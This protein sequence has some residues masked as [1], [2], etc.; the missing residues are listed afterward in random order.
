MGLI[1]HGLSLGLPHTVIMGPWGLKWLGWPSVLA[2]L[3]HG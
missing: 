3:D 1:D 2:I